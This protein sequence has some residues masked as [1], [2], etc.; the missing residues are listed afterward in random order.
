M[1]LDIFSSDEVKNFH[2]GYCGFTTMR[3][4]FILHYGKQ[5]FDDYNNILR[6][7][8]SLSDEYEKMFDKLLNEIG[9]LKI[10]IDH[11]DC[12]GKLTV[13]ECKKLKECLFVDEDKINSLAEDGDHNIMIRYMYDFIDL[14]DYAVENNVEL[15]FG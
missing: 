15:I 6:A 14:V 12:D 5:L 10:L 4:F 1:G 13:E 7:A 2:I 8:F 11:S 3:G 9:D